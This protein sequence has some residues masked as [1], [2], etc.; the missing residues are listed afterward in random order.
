MQ[1]WLQ[2]RLNNEIPIS[3]HME[4]T[5]ITANSQEVSV[6]APLAPN[7]NHQATV[8]G[9]TL[10]SALL[11]SGWGLAE[12]R[13]HEW[14]HQGHIVIMKTELDYQ[15]PVN[16]DFIATCRLDEENKW[17][18]FRKVLERR[19]KARIWLEGLIRNDEGA[20]AVKLNGLYVASL[21]D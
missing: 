1:Q 11:L 2:N 13:L 19:K 18:D 4:L 3:K 7:I 15:R 5:V 8:F 16:G 9:G 21:V 14:G 6:A 10:A 17:E 20:P 12:I